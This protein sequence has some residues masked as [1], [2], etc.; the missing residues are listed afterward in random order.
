M[1]GRAR[2]LRAGVH[3]ARQARL[4]DLGVLQGRARTYGN[5]VAIQPRARTSSNARERGE[6]GAELFLVPVSDVHLPFVF[7]IRLFRPILCV[8]LLRRSGVVTMV[9]AFRISSLIELKYRFS[10]P[11]VPGRHPIL[12]DRATR[13]CHAPRTQQPSEIPGERTSV[14]PG[15]PRTR[16]ARVLKVGLPEA[17][18]NHYVRLSSIRIFYF[19]SAV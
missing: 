9:M 2:V 10:T 15:R 8:M 18:N 17:A 13:P 11:A 12:R 6:G 7:S 5:G 14:A 3:T 16:R 4:T 19:G 1:L